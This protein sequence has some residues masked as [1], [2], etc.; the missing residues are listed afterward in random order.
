MLAKLNAVIPIS[1][2]TNFVPI[3]VRRGGSDV[4]SMRTA[5]SAERGKRR[6]PNV[7]R[8]TLNGRKR[9]GAN[10]LEVQSEP[11]TEGR[12][13]AP[14]Q[15]RKRSGLGLPQGLNFSSV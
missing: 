14:F 2:M 6:T 11:S 12:L 4:Y 8:R 7:Q 5:G 15:R 9:R 10:N 3:Q 1:A 13:A